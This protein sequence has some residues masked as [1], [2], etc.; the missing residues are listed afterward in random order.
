MLHCTR[1]AKTYVSTSHNSDRLWLV[2]DRF[3]FF[4][5]S[6]YRLSFILLVWLQGLSLVAY[7][8]R[9]GIPM[10]RVGNMGRLGI[11]V[12]LIWG[13]LVGGASLLWGELTR[14]LQSSLSDSS[15]NLVYGPV[16]FILIVT[17][18]SL[19]QPASKWMHWATMGH[20]RTPFWSVLSSHLCFLPGD[21]HS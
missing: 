21:S 7:V 12:T 20:T 1:A 19:I 11:G 18:T 2:S 4:M 16:T 6:F 14:N 17:T 13:E 3:Y 9:V 10:G 5:S 8:G 15:I